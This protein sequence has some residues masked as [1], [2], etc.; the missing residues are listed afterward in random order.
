M[1]VDCTLTTVL[2]AQ[3]WQ[4]GAHG[5]AV[6]GPKIICSYICVITIIAISSK[7]VK[8]R[9][10]GVYICSHICSY[11]CVI[12]IIVQKKVKEEMT[13]WEGVGK[14]FHCPSAPVLSVDCHGSRCIF[15][16][17]IHI[18]HGSREVNSVEIYQS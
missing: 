11:N 3:T 7:K 8:E 17:K 13:W 16:F 4:R 5:S 1:F 12:T 18:C 15:T 10:E 9:W 2:I 14:W 6:Y